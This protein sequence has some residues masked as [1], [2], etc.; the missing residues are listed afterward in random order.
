MLRPQGHNYLVTLLR[1]SKETLLFSA[2]TVLLLAGGLAWLLAAQTPTDVL[3]YAGNLL[4]LG[5][6]V[7]WTVSAIRRHQL[8]VD[9]I[10]VLALAGAIAV[11]EPFA[12]AMIT[13]MLAS[14]QLLE[15][16]AAARA[17]RELSLL[18]ERA[19]RTARRRLEGGVVEVGVDEVSRGDRILVGTGEV[20]PVDGRLVAG[21]TLDEAAL[22]GESLPVERP[23]G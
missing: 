19:P 7:V 13:V 1:A 6:S 12:G 4:G 15:A 10:A 16:R 18:V 23:A 5:F 3:W 17:R 2:S 9:V 11:R 14:G 22:T 21:G 20:V 8:S